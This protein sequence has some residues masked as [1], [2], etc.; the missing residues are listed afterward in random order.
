MALASIPELAA[1]TCKEI[2]ASEEGKAVSG[3]YWLNTIIPGTPAL[4]Y[5]EMKAEGEQLR[6]CLCQIKNMKFK[7]NT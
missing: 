6:N 7:A 1:E 5:C 2:E 4:V 3:R